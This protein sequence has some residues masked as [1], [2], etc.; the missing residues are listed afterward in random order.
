MLRDRRLVGYRFRRQHPLGGFILDFACTRYRLAVEADGG[1]HADYPAD[2]RRTAILRKQ[3]WRVLRFW[4][5]DI[6]TNA[7]GV[8]LTILQALKRP[9]PSPGFGLRPQPPSPAVRERGF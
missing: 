7:E 2:E 6:L 9:R 1:Q 8:I 4:N 5:N 3:G